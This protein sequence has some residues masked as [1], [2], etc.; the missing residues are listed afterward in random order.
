[1]TCL[2]F[3]GFSHLVLILYIKTA[4]LHSVLSF[5]LRPIPRCCKKNFRYLLF[6]LISYQVLSFPIHLP[7]PLFH[8]FTPSSLLHSFIISSFHP[9]S[10][11]FLPLLWQRCYRCFHWPMARH[12]LP[13]IQLRKVS[14]PLYTNWLPILIFLQLALPIQL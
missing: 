3:S 11:V 10:C 2:A 4:R 14:P 12:S 7:S 5:L 9:S 6:S 13:V 8:L 1:M